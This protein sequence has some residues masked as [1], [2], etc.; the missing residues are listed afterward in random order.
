MFR[1][2]K[3]IAFLGFFTL[4]STSAS[5]QPVWQSYNTSEVR[6]G[7]AICPVND[8]Q[9]GNFFCFALSCPQEG[10]RE[11]SITYAGG[12][13]PGG[14]VTA[15]LTINGSSAPPL[16]MTETSRSDYVELRA[17]WD[18]DRDSLMAD[19]LAGGG[20][21]QLSL[22]A[23]N[24]EA[25]YVL[26]LDTA[27]GPLGEVFRICP[28]PGPPPIADPAGLAQAEAAQFCQ[29]NGG[30]LQ[31]GDG[32]LSEP[33][34]N[35]D[36]RKDLVLDWGAFACTGNSVSAYCGSAGCVHGLYIALK[37]GGYKELFEFNVHGYDAEVMPV[38][39]LYLHGGACGGI[40]ADRCVKY[41]TIDDALE[42]DPLD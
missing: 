13:A 3:V 5:A 10:P 2:G 4:C 26:P 37:D 29:Q 35:G 6:Q 15:R 11:W 9:T 31:V 30:V 20:V 22:A 25:S 36:G 41:F 24:W 32:F 38:I 33:D 40:G 8:A 14:D 27:Q 17:P 42:L 34:L 12:A 39:T 28:V 1:I 19:Q 16:L 18:A 7:A 21:A 23:P